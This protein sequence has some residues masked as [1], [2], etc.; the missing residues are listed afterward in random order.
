MAT[1]KRYS[2]QDIFQILKE[3]NTIYENKSV[4]VSSE[5]SDGK[6]I[7]TNMNKS[8]YIA[9]TIAHELISTYSRLACKQFTANKKDVEAAMRVAGFDP[10]AYPNYECF[11]LIKYT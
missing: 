6:E 2:L 7:E 8:E 5:G 11:G 9:M 1:E 10:I 3:A 4:T